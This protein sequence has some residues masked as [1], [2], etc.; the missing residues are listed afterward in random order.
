MGLEFFRNPGKFY[1]GNLHTH[2]WNS[3]GLLSPET[4]C[5]KYKDEG[6]DFISLT[7]HFVGLYNYPIT[8]TEKFRSENFSTML[9]AEVHSG[10]ME[11]GE[12]WHILAVGL[13]ENFKPPNCPS[14]LPVDDQESAVELAKRCK[15]AGAFI[16]IAH[17]QW[18][19]MSFND[20]V[21]L[22]SLADSV[23]IYNHGC[24]VDCDRPD[25]THMLDLLSSSGFRLNAIATDD[26]H[27]KTRDF[28]GGWVYVK[29][30]KND[31]NHL[32]SALK[33]GDYYSSSGPLIKNVEFN[34]KFIEITCS[35]AQKVIALGHGSASN[36]IQ[37]E[38]LTSCRINLEMFFN[39]KWI[40]I[41]VI[42][43][44]SKKAWTNP[45]W[46]QK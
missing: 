37:G 16:S 43:K 15:E 13:P 27:F 35:E 34:E 10:S 11:N 29:A 17:P 24:A 41:V 20:A 18:S 45:I 30:K 39:S 31:P 1:R 44:N 26:A 4:V 12:I 32:L 6:Y 42:D 5:K 7:D 23:E 28:F 9:G 46:I 40:R 14:F 22:A 38:N 8:K 36:S 19:G 33:N 2:S 21:S 25:G 3:D